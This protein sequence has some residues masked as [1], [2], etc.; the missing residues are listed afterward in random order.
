[1]LQLDE[2]DGIRGSRSSLL[3]LE[4]PCFSQ[5]RDPGKAPLTRFKFAMM[6][7]FTLA[8]IKLHGSTP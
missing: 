3:S 4:L 8:R 6:Q 5:M 7:G 1:V 2:I